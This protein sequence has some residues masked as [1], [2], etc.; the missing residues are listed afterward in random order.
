MSR[1]LNHTRNLLSLPRRGTQTSHGTNLK[2][3]EHETA[4]SGVASIGLEDCTRVMQ[5]DAIDNLTIN[6]FGVY[7]LE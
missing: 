7:Y 1:S 5:H 6:D 3:I 2:Q 4:S